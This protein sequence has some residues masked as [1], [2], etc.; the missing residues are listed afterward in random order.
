MLS[1]EVFRLAESSAGPP[2]F[3]IPRSV[4]LIQDR[5]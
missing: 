1:E 3:K 5:R 2:G 4:D